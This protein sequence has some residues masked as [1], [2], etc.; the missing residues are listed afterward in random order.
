M[1]LV[2]GMMDKAHVTIPEIP[3]VPKSHDDLFLSPART[4]IGERECVCGTRC[5]ANFIAK[6]RYGTD[7]DKAFVCK[8]YLL[9]DQYKDFLDGKGL[10]SMRSKCLLCSRYYLNYLYILVSAVEHTLHHM[11]AFYL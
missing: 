9:P 6:V 1:Q 11:C 7:T 4:S 8:E 3:L 10:P 5:L 2:S